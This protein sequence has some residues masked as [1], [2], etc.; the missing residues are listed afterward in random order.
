MEIAFATIPLRSICE[1]ETLARN[2]LGE[3]VA[4]TLMHRLADI[5]AAV[6]ITDLIVGKPEFIKDDKSC[7][8]INLREGYQLII[9]ANHP[10]NPATE[11]GE[12]DWR[13]IRRVKICEIVRTNEQN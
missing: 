1:S 13:K 6:C 7:L 2:E 4:N 9:S 8:S 5:R 12:L 3:L 11:S 10:F